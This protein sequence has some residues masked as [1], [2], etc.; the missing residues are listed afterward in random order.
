ME[1]ALLL[2][3]GATAVAAAPLA[4]AAPAVA[5]C[6]A[7]GE[8]T[9]NEGT[10]WDL[11]MLGR[12]HRSGGTYNAGSGPRPDTFTYV[13]RLYANLAD[14]NVPDICTD[15]GVT[16]ASAMRF[17]PVQEF[18]GGPP[19]SCAQIAPDMVET[20]TYTIRRV[21]MGL[22]FDYQ[23]AGGDTL[24]IN[25]RCLPGGGVGLPADA[26]WCSDEFVGCTDPN[27][28]TINWLNG[29]TCPGVTPPCT[30]DGRCTDDAGTVWNL[31]GTLGPGLGQIQ[32]IAG[33]IAGQ[34]YAFRLYSNL[35]TVP[36][37]C[38]SVGIT[39]ASALRYNGAGVD[40][41][42]SCDQIGP[43]MTFDPTYILR[44]VPDGLFFQYT[45]GSD[46]I[47]VNLICREGAGVGLPD[48]A[49][50]TPGDISID[51]FNGLV[52]SPDTPTVQ[53]I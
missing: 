21:P 13:Y 48:D 19:P 30:A 35:N 12:V 26:F 2:C 47:R 8:C 6:T 9:D 37:A 3:A 32:R 5:P 20:P 1:V 18:P 25:L 29:I 40:P 24:E 50:G 15:S 53:S 28:Y 33:P 10:V 43:D 39:T 45:F 22:T 36:N 11:S 46:I 14:V 31:A 16:T 34:T 44:R 23:F 41:Q 38:S 49:T 7:A 17:D 42:A 51:W 52:C 27:K 4:A